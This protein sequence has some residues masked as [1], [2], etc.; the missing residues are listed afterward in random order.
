M[1]QADFTASFEERVA[2][3]VLC[4]SFLPWIDDCAYTSMPTDTTGSSPVSAPTVVFTYDQIAN[5][6]T[7]GFW[8][9]FG[10]GQR[11]FAVSPGGTLFV[12]TSALTAGGQAMARQAL[13]AWSSV[14]G[15]V[16]TEINSTTA[17]ANSF[18][19]VSDAA[20]GP[21]SGYAISRGDDFLGTLSSGSDR[22]AIAVTLTAGQTISVTLAGDGR[23]GNPLFDPYLW[24]LDPTGNVLAQN[25]DATGNDSAITFQAA[26]AGT[27][28]IRAG[29]FNDAYAGDYRIAVRETSSTVDI[30]FDDEQ[31]GAFASSTIL[32]GKIQS[33]FV[34]VS[35]TW[36]GGSARTDGYYFQTFLHEIGHALGL[37]HAGNYNSSANYNSDALYLNDSW[38]SSVMSY[39][40]QAEN[41]WLNADFAYAITPMMADIIAIQALYG[42]PTANTGDTVYGDNGNTTTY[43]D[44]ALG[45]SNPVAF[46][47]F[48]TDGTDTFDFSSYTA[49][50]RLDL[51]QETYSDLAG[52]DG[53]IGIAR[54]TV[55]ENGLTGSGND[56]LTGNAA[57]NALSSGP[58][59]DTVNGGAGNDAI[60][61]GTGFDTLSGGDGFDLIEGGSGD[62]SITGGAGGDLLIGGEVTLANLKTLFPTWTPPPNAQTLL[63]AG[64]LMALWQDILSDSG[65]A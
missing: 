17:P 59:N 65:F 18:T 10:G 26:A 7:D 19:E 61:G 9:S 31:P 6:L 34:N 12:D 44:A 50:Q 49:H 24:I 8:N 54:G 28:Y 57:A 60:R 4:Q 35:A 33:A 40:H 1:L 64:D 29:S 27:Y 55:I 37:G 52:L 45:L 21:G 16:F 3:C 63:N 11:A 20:P 23:N 42:T 13:D 43:L 36:A 56:T 15:I 32:N 39:F 2:V 22:D 58:G 41:T 38:Q 47:V 46:T 14:T 48:D 5:Q 51:R 30:V 62:N 25:D 53:N